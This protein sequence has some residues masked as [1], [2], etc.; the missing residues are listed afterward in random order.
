MVGCPINVGVGNF[1]CSD[2]KLTS[3]EHSPVKVVGD[4][5]CS[6]N[7]LTSLEYSPVSV[8]GNFDCY[9]NK[10]ND[11]EGFLYSCTSEQ[12]SQYYKNKHLSEDLKNSLS[13]KVDIDIKRKKL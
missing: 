2:N 12:V 10:L 3:L 1:Y 6:G 13:E 4:F 7:Q 8:G 9:D 11:S 5:Y